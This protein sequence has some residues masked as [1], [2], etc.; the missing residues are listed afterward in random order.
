MATV[1]ELKKALTANGSDEA[2]Q[3]TRPGSK[4]WGA[5]WKPW[6]LDPETMRWEAERAAAPVATRDALY[7]ILAEQRAILAEQRSTSRLTRWTFIAAAAAVVLAA[8][9]LV[10]AVIAL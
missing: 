2:E 4:P 9:S 3:T 5:G 10:V 7:A 8:A 6:D 1:S